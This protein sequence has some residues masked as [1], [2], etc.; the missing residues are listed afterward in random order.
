M[1]F[2]ITGLAPQSFAHLFGLPDDVLSRQNIVRKTADA[3]PGYPCRITLQDAEPGETV[4]LLNHESH[5]APTPYA[6]RYAIYVREGAATASRYRNELPPVFMGRPIALRMFSAEG[7]LLGADLGRGEE[8]VAK[9]EAAFA[10]ADVAYI[11]AHNAMHGC[12]S[13]EIRRAD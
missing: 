6:S 9:I 12:F 10:R 4:L 11:H 5:S 3:Q 2:V 1:S 13:A 7:M 8:L